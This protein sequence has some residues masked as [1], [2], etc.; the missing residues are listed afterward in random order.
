M[1]RV[2]VLLLSVLFCLPVAGSDDTEL[3]T[4]YKLPVWLDQTQRVCP[5][6]SRAG[7]G[8]IRLIRTETDGRH[9]LYL[10]WIRKGIAGTPT[11]AISTVLVEELAGDLAVRFEMPDADVHPGRCQMMARAEDI[12]TERRYD[13]LLTL[14][15]PGDYQLEVTMLYSGDL[16]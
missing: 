8:Y 13:L 10:Q 14:T 5:W 2:I 12:L 4:I 15:G 7:E 16:E 6:K 3:A 1:T 11:Q 9:Q